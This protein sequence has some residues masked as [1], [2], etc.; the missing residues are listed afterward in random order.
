VIEEIPEAWRINNRINLRQIDRISDVGM[1]C[2]MA[3][4]R[5]PR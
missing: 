2:T 5:S 3:S 4:A 1:R